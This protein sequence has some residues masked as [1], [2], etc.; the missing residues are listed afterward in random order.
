VFNRKSEKYLLNLNLLFFLKTIKKAL[1]GKEFPE[2]K[3][4]GKS[5]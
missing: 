5:I 1:I 2:R 4:C 3:I